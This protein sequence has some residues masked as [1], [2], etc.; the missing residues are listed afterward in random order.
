MKDEKEFI[1]TPT[2][3]VKVENCDLRHLTI[4]FLR[5]LKPIFQVYIQLVMQYY[6]DK[7]MK[8]GKLATMLKSKKKT[9]HGKQ[10][11]ETKL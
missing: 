1:F 4:R 7:Y 9:L 8:S 11:Q 10:G 6:G 5:S 3:S 2:L